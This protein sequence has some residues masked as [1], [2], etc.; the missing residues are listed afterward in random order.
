MKRL[1]GVIS[2]LLAAAVAGCAAQPAPV[3]S[4]GPQPAPQA[5]SAF[6]TSSGMVVGTMSYHYVEV[7]G[8][9]E[10]GSPVWVVHLQRIDTGTTDDY[11][12]PVSVDNTRHRGVFVGALP[13]GV[14]AFREAATAGRHFPPTAVKMPFEV[15][16]GE[17]RDAGHYALNPVTLN[18]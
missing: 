12:L 17:V 6:L 11:A 4:L 2:G 15:L 13:A 9:N 7:G 18:Q 10:H 3:R 8:P 5:A 16:A 14:Y 1:Y